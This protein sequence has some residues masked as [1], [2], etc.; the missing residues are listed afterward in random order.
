MLEQ[1]GVEAQH[2]QLRPDRDLDTVPGQHVP[3]P[4]QGRTDDLGDI[5]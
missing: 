2:R 5:D 3:G 1:H 4:L